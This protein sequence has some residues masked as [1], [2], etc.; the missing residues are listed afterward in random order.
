MSN[1]NIK[2]NEDDDEFLFNQEFSLEENEGEDTFSSDELSRLVANDV[3]GADMADQSSL[4]SDRYKQDTK[5]RGW[6]SRWVA[7]VVSLWLLAVILILV[8][9]EPLHLNISD[10]VRCTLL[11]TTSANVLGLPYIVLKGLFHTQKEN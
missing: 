2:L 9:N 10:I 7:W 3:D 8:L 1:N 5:A 11:G 6:L 4:K